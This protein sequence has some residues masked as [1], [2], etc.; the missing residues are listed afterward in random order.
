MAMPFA[1]KVDCQPG[2]GGEPTPHT[3]HFGLATVAVKDLLDSWPGRDHHYFKLLG[4]DGA[5]YIVRH[6]LPSGLWE[7]AFY[8]RGGPAR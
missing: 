6:D 5:T 4:E 1:I 8:D 3:L 2:Q 7:L